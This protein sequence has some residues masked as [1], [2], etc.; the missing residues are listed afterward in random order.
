MR[1][2]CNFNKEYLGDDGIIPAYAG[3]TCSL[4]SFRCVARDHPRICGEHTGKVADGNQ[5]KGSSPHMRGTPRLKPSFPTIIGIIPAYAGNTI[6]SA[7]NHPAERDHPRICG[8]HVRELSS[9]TYFTGDHPR[10]CGEHAGD[11]SQV[12]DLTGSSPHMRG[13]RIVFDWTV[14]DPGIIPAYAGNTA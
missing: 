12:V 1:G 6:R 3:N 10:I 13:T 14:Y 11:S 2:T 5:G 8:E 9:R 4:F 7:S